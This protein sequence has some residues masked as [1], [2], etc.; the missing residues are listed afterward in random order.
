MIVVPEQ[1]IVGLVTPADAFAAVQAVFASMA[2]G[3]R[4]TSR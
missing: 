4:G 3:E 1:E 2:R